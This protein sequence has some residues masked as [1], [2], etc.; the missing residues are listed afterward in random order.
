MSFRNS[1]PVQPGNK[2]VVVIGILAAVIAVFAIA[3]ND[4]ISAAL[5]GVALLGTGLLLVLPA[6]GTVR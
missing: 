5:A 6:R 4:R 2:R 3:D 1:A